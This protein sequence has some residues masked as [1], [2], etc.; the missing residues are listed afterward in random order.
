MA[1]SDSRGL[2]PSS[3]D[4]PGK[5]AAASPHVT[6]Q[7]VELTNVK[8][9][10]KDAPPS[11]PLEEDIMQ[12][13]RLGETGLIQKMLESGKFKPTYKDEENITPLHVCD[14]F[15]EASGTMLIHLFIVGGD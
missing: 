10:G 5:A 1:S 6:P 15:Y 13:A 14:H 7:D 9:Q 12:C 8:G 4:G 11:L 2:R 3:A